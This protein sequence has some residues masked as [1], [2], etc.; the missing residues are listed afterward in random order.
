[1]HFKKSSFPILSRY[2]LTQKTK[3]NQFRNLS[4]NTLKDVPE[5]TSDE[6]FSSPVWKKT[7]LFGFCSFVIYK[8]DQWY[9][10]LHEGKGFFTRIIEHFMVNGEEATRLYIDRLK[11][12]SDSIKE[13]ARYQNFKR[14]T[15]YRLKFPEQLD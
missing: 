7:I 3:K 5:F 8:I 6:D 1:M 10:S 9:S 14:E 13:R 11:A 4:T 15:I 12:S 2:I